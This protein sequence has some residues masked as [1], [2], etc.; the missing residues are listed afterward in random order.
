MRKSWSFVP[1]LIWWCTVEQALQYFFENNHEF[2]MFYPDTYGEKANETYF[3][4]FDVLTLFDLKCQMNASLVPVGPFAVKDIFSEPDSNKLTLLIRTDLKATRNFN[5]SH[6]ETVKL[7]GTEIYQNM[8]DPVQFKYDSKF[9]LDYQTYKTTARCFYETVI[10]GTFESVGHKL[11]TEVV[12][13]PICMAPHVFYPERDLFHNAF[14]MESVLQFY[15]T[16][17][18]QAFFDLN[19]AQIGK[20]EKAIIKVIFRAGQMI[21][22]TNPNNQ[23]NMRTTER[24]ENEAVIVHQQQAK[25]DT[26]PTNCQSIL[27]WEREMNLA[28]SHH[29]LTKIKMV[30]LSTI[31]S[32]EKQFLVYESGQSQLFII[33]TFNAGTQQTS[34]LTSFLQDLPFKV[35]SIKY[36]HGE[37]LIF[38]VPVNL[39]KSTEENYPYFMNYYFRLPLGKKVIP[40]MISNLS[41][42]VVGTYQC[43]YLNLDG[44]L[45]LLDFQTPDLDGKI[46]E[47]PITTFYFSK[48]DNFFE[49]YMEEVDSLSSKGFGN[50]SIEAV[51]KMSRT[52]RRF[53]TKTYVLEYFDTEGADVP[54]NPGKNLLILTNRRT[55]RQMGRKLLENINNIYEITQFASEF[56]F[57]FKYYSDKKM[58]PDANQTTS[59][60]PDGLLISFGL[61]NIKI[62]IKKPPPKPAIKDTNK[63]LERTASPQTPNHSDKSSRRLQGPAA[64]PFNNKL[65]ITVVCNGSTTPSFSFSVNFM[66][67]QNDYFQS[68]YGSSLPGDKQLQDL[69][70]ETDPNIVP[71]NE[72]FSNGID[73]FLNM[74]K[75]FKGS[76]FYF[77]FNSNLGPR[78]K[79][80]FLFNWNVNLRKDILSITLPSQEMAMP[81]YF[82]VQKGKLS[83]RNLLLDLPTRTSYYKHINNR[84]TWT[85]DAVDSRK[86]NNIEHIVGQDTMLNVSRNIFSLNMET[87]DEKPLTGIG[88]FCKSV[89]FCKMNYIPEITLCLTENSL[90]AHYT[91][92]RF[93]S[94]QT[95]LNIYDSA[96]TLSE[97]LK[98]KNIRLMLYTNYFPSHIYLFS[99][100]NGNYSLVVYEFYAGMDLY[101]HSEQE[102]K[103]VELTNHLADPAM[104]DKL[105]KLE[106]LDDYI[107][108]VTEKGYFFSYNIRSSRFN[109]TKV[110]IMI[111]R[112]S[113]LDEHFPEYSLPK[114]YLPNEEPFKK[115]TGTKNT[116]FKISNLETIKIFSEPT[117]DNSYQAEKVYMNRMVFML[118]ISK[119]FGSSY[120]FTSIVMFDHRQSSYQAFQ[121]IIRG[122]NCWR[123]FIGPAFIIEGERQERSLC[124]ICI[125]GEPGAPAS[126]IPQA[127]EAL[128][129][130]LETSRYGIMIANEFK[131]DNLFKNQD[132]PKT[133]LV[134]S[135]YDVNFYKGA[136]MMEVLDR[137]YQFKNESAK[138]LND[139][140]K[141]INIRKTVKMYFLDTF[142]PSINNSL[143]NS[144]LHESFE[145]NSRS[146]FERLASPARKNA[147]REISDYFESHIF[148]TKVKC[149]SYIECR[150]KT[151][152]GTVQIVES[153]QVASFPEYVTMAQY[154]IGY[155][156]L[157]K[158]Y[159]DSYEMAYLFTKDKLTY[160][161]QSL[162]HTIEFNRLGNE[163]SEFQNFENFMIGVCSHNKSHN[164]FRVMNLSGDI[165]YFDIPFKFKSGKILTVKEISISIR[166]D[167]M[168]LFTYNVFFKRYLTV[169]LFQ[170]INNKTYETFDVSQLNQTTHYYNPLVKNFSIIYLRENPM[171]DESVDFRVYNSGSSE[172]PSK[173]FY[174]WSLRRIENR[175]LQIKFDGFKLTE[176][177]T[178]GLTSVRIQKICDLIHLRV[179]FYIPVGISAEYLIDQARV[180]PLPT[181]NQHFYDFILT[182]PNAQDYFMRVNRTLLDDSVKNNQIGDIQLQN[183]SI[184]SI[185]NPFFGTKNTKV[186]K[187]R[188]YNNTYMVGANYYPNRAIIRCYYIPES[189]R[190][191]AVTLTI[192][193][194]F[195]LFTFLKS[196]GE[197]LV[198]SNQTYALETDLEANTVYTFGLIQHDQHA[199]VIGTHDLQMANGDFEPITGSSVSR[200]QLLPQDLLLPG[201]RFA[202]RI[203]DLAVPA[204]EGEQRVPGFE[205]HHAGLPRPESHGAPA[206]QLRTAADAD[207]VELQ[208]TDE[209]R[210]VL[211]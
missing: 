146:F 123:M 85:K 163:C 202:H 95:K 189:L 41:Q 77:D 1:L 124:I 208:P 209:S 191:R 34:N 130:I 56:T 210:H 134:A 207:R 119:N 73:V 82:E 12:Q 136:Y 164:Y 104:K 176:E 194:N 177:K 52:F 37:F 158:F 141:A 197:E 173:H 93:S 193:S 117:I 10:F 118:E 160:T 44:S 143:A 48:I 14:T 171:N 151:I 58:D 154:R 11:Q 78:N 121:P 144:L 16:P 201:R 200:R 28:N 181:E 174:L 64:A 80:P 79:N 17:E 33:T 168:V 116:V 159:N 59:M 76:F 103:L 112:I 97:V 72:S 7:D 94:E 88:S 83:V 57:L 84:W 47:I 20:G 22:M 42:L 166:E 54:G 100:V 60:Y 43:A 89:V 36:V 129:G 96:G 65:N 67:K 147:S 24:T 75:F 150:D 184:L 63:T 107:V 70:L 68:F 5:R 179:K 31:N 71:F 26:S 165:S 188:F 18:R 106:C 81:V 133:N 109:Y 40:G 128:I 91:S 25:P 9:L 55:G 50:L 87:L 183:V 175:V 74:N 199:I 156:K 6:K 170:I 192:K 196:K 190:A 182:L 148:N 39:T 198:N 178:S 86:I 3:V 132:N 115:Y 21:Q 61:P 69:G 135:S 46:D 139:F 35:H 153:N 105:N 53:M 195:E 157:P 185:S 110:T 161:H 27:L 15:M 19:Y 131:V 142:K 169:F 2:Y 152:N 90:Q 186:I 49:I 167:Y 125:Q 98:N 32:V 206:G 111:Q 113:S 38:E 13:R 4:P 138:Q 180:T 8:T 114:D 62:T 30:P 137:P 122:D 205:Q 23:L 99:E 102:V 29:S 211:H 51:K 140:F 66:N 172:S 120:H 101:I 204:L 108:A 45:M 145:A 92:E 126:S 155:M 162:K 127:P 203:E 187:P 149:E